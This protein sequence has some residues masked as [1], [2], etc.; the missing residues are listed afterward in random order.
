MYDSR[1]PLRSRLRFEPPAKI[2]EYGS[3]KNS[4]IT[5]G[6]L[7][8]GHVERSII[9]PHVR[10]DKGAEVYDSL[11]MP[12]NHIGSGTAIRRSIL[13]TVSRQQHIDGRPNIGNDCIIG[14]YGEARANIEKPEI[15]NS[16]ITLIG[17]E[18]EI[19]AS[20]MIGRN[21]IIYPESRTTDFENRGLVGDGESV[22]PKTH[23]G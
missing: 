13:D 6:C 23:K 9:F 19:P 2:C 4:V 17:M 22:H 21:C 7:I 3:V 16:S 12:N 11:I 5:Q 1:N 10:I 15:L 14:G 20:T 18:S 8:D